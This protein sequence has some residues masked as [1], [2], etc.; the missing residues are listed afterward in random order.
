MPGDLESGGTDVC[1][2]ER[3]RDRDIY[4]GSDLEEREGIM[5]ARVCV[6][7][8]ERLVC[9]GRGGVLQIKNEGC[10]CERYRHN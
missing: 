10:M 3:Q 2:S 4:W 1:M 8:R 6:R 9:G 7:G 5:C